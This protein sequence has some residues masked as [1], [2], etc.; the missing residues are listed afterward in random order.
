MSTKGALA[1]LGAIGA[2]GIGGKVGGTAGMLGAG[3]ATLSIAAAS[4][5]S[6]AIGVLSSLGLAPALAAGAAGGLLGFGVGMQHGKAA[7]A[8]TGAATGLGT[9][10]ILTALGVGLGPVGWIAAGLIGLFGG[11]FGGILG[12]SKRRKQA[13]AFSQ[14][15]LAE[16]TKLED[17]Y[18]NF[19]VDSQ[20]ALD[21]L[22]AMRSASW[23]E[24]QQLKGEGKDVF[25]KKVSP[26]I[27]KAEEY[28]R[29]IQGERDRRAALFFGP[30]QFATGGYIGGS[31]IAGW[32][33]GDGAVAMIGHEG[34]MMMNREATRRNRSLLEDLNSGGSGRTSAGGSVSLH[35]STLDGP[36]TAYW[37][38]NGGAKQIYSALRRGS[39]EGGF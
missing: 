27:D 3:L 9:A 30:P 12:G 18:N 19:Q 34:E 38:K 39:V 28:I 6:A 36:S 11:L 4:G 22:E 2:I 35:L 14:Q 32:R 23:A 20:S 1:G 37:L 5:N 15:Q 33:M 24:L 8:I 25:Q 10:G 13:D 29:G 26:G 7:G 21:Q 31:R 16:V 17:A